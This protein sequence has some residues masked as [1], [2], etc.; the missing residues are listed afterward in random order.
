MPHQFRSIIVAVRD[1]RHP[2]R[3][4]LRQAAAIARRSKAR[5]ELL[6]VLATPSAYDSVRFSLKPAQTQKDMVRAAE[7]QLTKIAHS[8]VMRSVEVTAHASW[9][10]PAAEVIAQR[11]A[12]RRAD[13]VIVETR[14]HP[15]ASRFFLHHADWELIRLCAAP[16]LLVKAGRAYEGRNVLAAVDPFHRHAKPAHLDRRILDLAG[17]LATLFRGQL[18]AAHVYVPLRMQMPMLATELAMAW[19]PPDADA[20]YAGQVRASLDRLL[21]HEGVPTRHAHLEEGEVSAGLQD[22]V[23]RSRAGIVVMGAVSRSGPKRLVLGSTVERVLDALP[24][25]VLVVKPRGFRTPPPTAGGTLF[26]SGPMP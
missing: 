24:C 5:V 25:D 23:R 13:L 12:R 26:A 8:A 22:A 9:G 17:A 20:R 18:H 4:A 6:H 1:P 14:R 7:M 16:L 2:P 15:V 21:A 10:Y 3:R 19:F 11:A